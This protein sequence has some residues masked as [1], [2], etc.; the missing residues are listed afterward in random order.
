MDGWMNMQVHGAEK[1]WLCS[2]AYTVCAILHL[3]FYY[4]VFLDSHN[5]YS[6]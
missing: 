3:N 1:N 6:D 5:A 2:C 4:D